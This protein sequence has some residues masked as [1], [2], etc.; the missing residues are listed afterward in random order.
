VVNSNIVYKLISSIES[1][2]TELETFCA[3]ITLQD[4]SKDIKLQRFTE[5]TL[6]IAIEAMLDIAHHIIS[7][8]KYREP[9]SYADAFT[10]LHENGILD[11]GFL[12][13]V[14]QMAQ[15]RNKL[16]HS[17]ESIDQEILFTIV[18]HKRHDIE[19]FI[20]QIKNWIELEQRGNEGN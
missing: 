13:T 18:I 20:T 14:K 5:R 2:L 1:Y 6:Q 7:D 19:N 15:F 16:V 8:E 10:V 3:G 11:E 12:K 17:Y 4:F 9:D